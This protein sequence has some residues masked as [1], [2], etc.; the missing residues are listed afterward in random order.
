MGVPTPAPD[1]TSPKDEPVKGSAWTRL[2]ARTTTVLVF[3][4]GN[5]LV[6]GCLFGPAALDEVPTIWRLLVGVFANFPLVRLAQAIGTSVE[7]RV[8]P[9][10]R[11]DSN[12]PL[13]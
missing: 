13:L 1:S 7:K 11:A 3:A 5:L 4:A 6:W 2:I 10:P 9:A 12:N 8:K